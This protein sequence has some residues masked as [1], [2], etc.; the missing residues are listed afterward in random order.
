M[1]PFALLLVWQ[2][3]IDKMGCTFFPFV[4]FQPNEVKVIEFKMN[5]FFVNMYNHTQITL[6]LSPF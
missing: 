5:F 3:V 4:I 6:K 2:N 1:E